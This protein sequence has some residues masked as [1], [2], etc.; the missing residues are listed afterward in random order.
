MST[1]TPSAQHSVKSSKKPDKKSRKDPFVIV[2]PLEASGAHVDLS[3]RR[4]G[5]QIYLDH[6]RP[7]ECQ[8]SEIE[9][10]YAAGHAFEHLYRCLDQDDQLSAAA[11]LASLGLDTDSRESLTN[12]WHT[13]WSQP[14]GQN[15]EKTWRVLYQWCVRTLDHGKVE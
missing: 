7:T 13:R 11:L 6:L 3:S 15:K 10:L 2:T 14:S 4:V 5:A 9:R 1:T 8:R 12:R